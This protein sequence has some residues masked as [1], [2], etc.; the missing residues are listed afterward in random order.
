MRRDPNKHPDGRMSLIEHL[1]ELRS[2]ILRSTI[3]FSVAFGLCWAASGPILR[4]LLQPVRTWLPPGEDIVYLELTEPFLVYMKAAAL[5]AVFLCIPYLLYQLWA[6]VAPGLYVNES[7]LLLPF[8]F[9]GTLCFGIGGAFGYFVAAPMTAKWLVALGADFRAAVTMRSAFRF[10]SWVILGMGAV[11]ELPVVIF[12]LSRIGVVTPQFLI[13]HFR[14]ALV[15]IA[16]LSAV[17]TPTGDVL[18]MSVFAVPMVVLYL[19]GVAVAWVSQR[20]AAARAVE[21]AG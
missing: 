11:F 1:D 5:A 16:L 10:L 13:R 2:R 12:F 17:L 7:R 21:N 14:I 19:I 4:F 3:V 8:L 18:T 6:F 15:T 20:R 9:F